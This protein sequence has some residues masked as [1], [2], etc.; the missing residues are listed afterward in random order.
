MTTD[1]P[2]DVAIDV[3]II[4]GS[5]AGISAGLQLARARKRVTVFDS[6]LRR[7]RFATHA[8]GFVAQ[9]GRPPDEIA[10]DARDQLLKY[11][12]VTWV[13]AAVES[14]GASGEGFRL[15]AGGRTHRAK[16]VILSM[17]VTDNLPAIPGLRERWGR[18]V[19][20][21]PYCHGYELGQGEIGVIAS[22]P[23]SMHQ[24]LLLPEWGRTTFFLNDAFEPSE[25]ESAELARRGITVRRGKVARISGGATVHVEG[26]APARFA[27]LFVA[28]RT[29]PSS[30]LAQ[31]LGCELEAGPM[32][33]FIR[34][35]MMKET[36]VPGVFA[37]GDIAR[38]A[39]NVAM[40][41]GDGAMA[42]A[43]AHRSLILGLQATGAL[44]ARQPPGTSPA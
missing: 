39:G 11:P 44:P 8:H 14:T 26:E 42:G 2:I 18:H 6:G 25:E 36:T 31:Q 29:E 33:E 21:C 9:D 19:F 23:V 28:T 40:A 10:A 43:A 34:T 37:C 12:T 7:N 16:R 17:G 15:E 24:A 30:P 3:A 27:G 38:A 35:G 4:G 13:D 32:G 1:F 5:Y 22:G 41:V 20:H